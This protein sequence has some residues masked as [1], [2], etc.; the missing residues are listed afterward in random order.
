MTSTA[1]LA[2]LRALLDEASAGFWTDAQLYIYLDSAQSAII[3]ELLAKQRQMK[4]AKGESFEVETLKPLIKKG[5]AITLISASNSIA[6]TSLTDIIEVYAV[7]LY[8]SVANV[9]LPLTKIG[10]YDLRTRVANTYTGHI[11]DTATNLGQVYYAVYQGAIL[12]S[13][14]DGALPYASTVFTNAA[15]NRCDV[16]Y[17]GQPTAVAA[18]QNYILP[19]E[20]HEAGI[21]IAGAL[22]KYQDGKKQEGD[23]FYQQGIQSIANL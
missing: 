20:T 1:M 19:S 7:E 22:A 3:T 13:F 5:G 15:L 12:T 6:L 9:K 4:V 17:Y 18:G 10:L 16:F 8:N 2:K 21:L 14:V 23:I 11:F